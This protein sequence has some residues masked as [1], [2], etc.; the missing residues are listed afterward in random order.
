MISY[1]WHHCF[2]I[3]N[4][5]SMRNMPKFQKKKKKRE[6]KKK[7]K[8]EAF[9][10]CHR[11]GVFAFQNMEFLSGT[12]IHRSKCKNHQAV[13]DTCRHKTTKN[14]QAR[15]NISMLPSSSVF[16]QVKM[17]YPLI[18]HI[19]S[20]YSRESPVRCGAQRSAAHSLLGNIRRKWVLT[21][22]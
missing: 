2:T 3:S 7:K 11:E 13:T 1:L 17:T 14:I 4:H 20:S 15:F 9:F 6:R 21:A 19:I 10:P 16:T 12:W 5:G 22:I 18:L 8:D